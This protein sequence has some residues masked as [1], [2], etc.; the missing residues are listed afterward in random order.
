MTVRRDDAVAERV[1]ARIEADG[2]SDVDDIVDASHLWRRGDL[3]P[4]SDEPRDE[5][6]NR[7]VEAQPHG[8]GRLRQHGAVGRSGRD[9][10]GVRE[11][12]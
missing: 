4:S 3:T 10:R 7:L 1:A 2:Q 8:A 11:S 5:D 6:R 12:R 9:Q